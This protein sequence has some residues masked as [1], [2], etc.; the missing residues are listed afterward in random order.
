MKSKDKRLLEGILTFAKKVDRRIEGLSL[1]KF[2]ADDDINEAVLYA[3]GQM[4][5]Y[6][7]RLSDAFREDYPEEIWHKLIGIRNRVF[8]SYEQIDLKKVYEL[9]EENIEH[10]INLINEIIG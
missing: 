6:T 10:T 4:G 2:L 9:A 8:H 5:E 7:I 1:E 3:I